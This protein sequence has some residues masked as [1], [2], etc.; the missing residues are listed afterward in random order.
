MD[1]DKDKKKKILRI[2][3]DVAIIA[4]IIAVT[5]VIIFFMYKNNQEK[6]SE[7]N[8]LS[9]TQLIDEVNKGNVEKIEMVSG[10]S[11]VT[12]KLKDVSF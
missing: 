3:L 6:N 8:T 4:L 2:V 10:S 7:E 11:S 12:V 9:Y 5:A 1:K